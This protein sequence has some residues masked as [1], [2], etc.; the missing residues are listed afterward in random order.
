[1]LK[2]QGLGGILPKIGRAGRPRWTTIPQRPPE[3]RESS[4]CRRKRDPE[5]AIKKLP[6]RQ[7]GICLGKTGGGRHARLHGTGNCQ[8]RKDWR[9]GAPKPAEWVLSPRRFAD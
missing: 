3:S 6:G 5:L 8:W 7:R 4:G 1:M 2:S 9:V